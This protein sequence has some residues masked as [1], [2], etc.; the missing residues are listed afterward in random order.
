MINYTVNANATM[1]NIPLKIYICLKPAFRGGVLEAEGTVEIRF[2]RKD[3]IKSMR[4]LD[5]VYTQIVEQLG[6]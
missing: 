4:R 1:K 6:E 5:K 2:R 3:L